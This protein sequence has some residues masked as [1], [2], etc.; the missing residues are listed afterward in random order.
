MT[1]D[2]AQFGGDAAARIR[3]DELAGAVSS[4]DLYTEYV[5]HPLLGRPNDPVGQAQTLERQM[6]EI[7]AFLRDPADAAHG[8]NF[9]NMRADDHQILPR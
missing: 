9:S 8:W 1:E 3:F 7:V 6:F 4:I 5:P 2:V